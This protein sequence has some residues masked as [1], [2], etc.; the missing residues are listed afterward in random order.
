M[1]VETLEKPITGEGQV[2]VPIQ[3]QGTEPLGDGETRPSGEAT[4]GD[5]PR[6]PSSEG[7]WSAPARPE[8]RV[9]TPIETVD[10]E[11]AT[12]VIGEPTNVTQPVADNSAAPEVAEGSITMGDSA[13]TS[14]IEAP[15]TVEIPV[16]GSK[17]D[18][19]F[20]VDITQNLPTAETLAEER[21]DNPNR[22][23]SKS[24]P[25]FHAQ[26]NEELEQGI[27]K[28]EERFDETLARVK[29]ELDELRERASQKREALSAEL[30]VALDEKQRLES[31]MKDRHAA[32]AKELGDNFDGKIQGLNQK[33][34]ELEQ[35]LSEI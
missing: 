21:T 25:E 22:G 14:K 34:A 26:A 1:A 9:T 31:E 20:G 4:L 11:T 12:P 27:A 30:Q 32:E 2:A 6:A 10:P 16:E 7:L 5:E 23:L 19:A 29:R 33:L 35:T 24:I 13:F 8:V 17:K 3:S 15:A 28:A 18:V